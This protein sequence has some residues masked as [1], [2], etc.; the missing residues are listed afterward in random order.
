MKISRIAAG[1][2]H[3]AAICDDGKLYMWGSNSYPV[4]ISTTFVLTGVDMGN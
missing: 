3:S 1:G 2:F 4:L